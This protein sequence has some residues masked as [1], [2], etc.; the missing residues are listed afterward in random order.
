MNNNTDDN[1]DFSLLDYHHYHQQDIP[2]DVQTFNTTTKQLSNSHIIDHHCSDYSIVHMNSRN[3]MT[4]NEHTNETIKEKIFSSLSEPTT[5][6]TTTTTQLSTLSDDHSD[7][8]VSLTPSS[9]S[10]VIERECANCMT[11][12]TPLWRRY[13]PNSFLCNACGL[14]QRVNGNHRPLMKNIRRNI[15]TTITKRTGLCC[16]NCGTKATSMW[17]RNTFGESVCNA[18]G[19]YFRL[20]GV[21]R[22]IEMRKEAVRTRKRRT[23]PMLMLRAML[24]PDFF[25]KTSSSSNNLVN[26][27][28]C[29]S[30]LEKLLNYKPQI[31]ANNRRFES[32]ESI[33]SKTN[34]KIIVNDEKNMM[35]IDNDNVKQFDH[36]GTKFENVKRK[37]FANSNQQ[38]IVNRYK[39]FEELVLESGTIF[40]GN[41]LPNNTID[42]QSS[43]SDP[44]IINSYSGHCTS[45]IPRTA[46]MGS[47]QELFNREKSCPIMMDHEYQNHPDTNID[48]DNMTIS[49]SY[50]QYSHHHHTQQD[51]HN[52]NNYENCETSNIESCMKPPTS[53]LNLAYL[54]QHYLNK[55]L[56][57]ESRYPK[58]VAMSS[59]IIMYQFMPE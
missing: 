52:S 30:S 12:N 24:G 42:W 51:G 53:I 14:Y 5:I 7:C 17:R 29:Q 46:I 19:L 58:I 55:L 2:D 49:E 25:T 28:E 45:S 34:E 27:I 41:Y 6:T 1:H 11:R 57:Y 37:K 36:Q 40:S 35:I 16:A 48:N 10:L 39:K 8:L 44:S 9:S 26:K 21:N 33:K 3:S 18:C 15:S 56:L 31:L 13:G 20:N 47:K 54:N 32:S 59:R 23:K 22:P 43:S 50:F 38:L 4:N